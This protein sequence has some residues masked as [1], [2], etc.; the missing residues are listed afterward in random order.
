MRERVLGECICWNAG[1]INCTHCSLCPAIAPGKLVRIMFGSYDEHCDKVHD[2]RRPPE[3]DYVTTA[4][5]RCP[6]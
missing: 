5:G 4:A 3:P 2:G 6:V 1:C